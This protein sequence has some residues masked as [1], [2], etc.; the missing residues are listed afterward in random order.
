[1][2]HIIIGLFILSALIHNADAKRVKL[3]VGQVAP[4]WKSL[5]G[6]DGKAHS[7]GDFK[8]AK[9]IAV[10]FTCNECPVAKSYVDRLN[11]IQSDFGKKGLALV[12]INPSKGE[13]E[14]LAAMRRLAK[15]SKFQFLYLRDERQSVAKA[16]GARV[17]PEVFVLNAKREIAYHG[18]IDD[19]R[20][21]KGKAKN[22]YLRD[23]I[24]AVL[25]GK[26]PAKTSSRPMGCSIRWK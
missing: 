19:D 12:A 18:A 25:S 21:L 10:I 24:E 23:A 11:K 15:K 1:M 8:K 22:H 4:S 7:S 9:A 5:P 14:S 6:V 26:Q 17:T 2:R 13:S 20:S 16:F 3:Q